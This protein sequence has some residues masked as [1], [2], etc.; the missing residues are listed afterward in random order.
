MNNL[1]FKESN[2][3]VKCPECD[4]TGRV[5]YER[6][7]WSYSQEMHYTVTEKADCPECGARGYMFRCELCGSLH[8]YLLAINDGTEQGC[9]K[10]AC[11]HCTAPRAQRPDGMF[12]SCC[13]K[14]MGELTFTESVVRT[15]GGEA[16]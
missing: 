13:N 4:G 9:E 16:A 3:R 14:C 12:P 2:W 7:C 5:E 10:C 8:D 15:I 11:P 1:S 6:D